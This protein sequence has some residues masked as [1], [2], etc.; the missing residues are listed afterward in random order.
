MTI[1]ISISNWPTFLNAILEGL[2]QL[3]VG[4]SNHIPSLT[5]QGINKTF[6]MWFLVLWFSC[7]Y[8]IIDCPPWCWEE[9]TTQWLST[10]C[11]PLVGGKGGVISHR[12]PVYPNPHLLTP[13]HLLIPH[14]TSCSPPPP[15]TDPYLL[16]PVTPMYPFPP[17]PLHPHPNWWH[18]MKSTGQIIELTCAAT[19]LC[20]SIT[21]SPLSYDS[22]MGRMF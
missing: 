3:V 14:P 15:P 2:Y 4:Q 21:T 9:L 7:F 12:S 5:S 19:W 6:G 22:Y 11:H 16:T 1:A 17:H 18:R 8:Y 10:W 20:T 13:I